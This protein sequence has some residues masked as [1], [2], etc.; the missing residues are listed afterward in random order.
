MELSCG[1]ATGRQTVKLVSTQCC[2]SVD[3]LAN[4]HFTFQP[5]KTPYYDVRIFV[6]HRLVQRQPILLWDL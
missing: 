2:A 4:G 5:R 3:N 1:L 6:K